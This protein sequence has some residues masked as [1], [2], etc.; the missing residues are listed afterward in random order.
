MDFS[1]LFLHFYNYSVSLKVTP[2]NQDNVEAVG[3]SE[4]NDERRDSVESII[5]APK[6]RK[7]RNWDIYNIDSK[8]ST[9]WGYI[10]I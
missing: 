10:F 8:K 2:E 9:R 1:A 3:Y 6:T 7:F 4:L 5:I